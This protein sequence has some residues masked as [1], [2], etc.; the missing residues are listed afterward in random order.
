MNQT[1]VSLAIIKFKKFTCLYDDYLCWP[2]TPHILIDTTQLLCTIAENSWLIYG[3]T[4]QL[5]ASSQSS[6]G[7][8]AHNHPK[9]SNHV[10]NIS[11]MP[12]C[13]CFTCDVWMRIGD[14]GIYIMM[15]KRIELP[16]NKNK[17]HFH[18]KKIVQKHSLSSCLRRAQGLHHFK[19][20]TLILWRLWN[21]ELVAYNN[22]ESDYSH[23]QLGR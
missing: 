8:I 1:K 6:P 20:M 22:T 21:S 18:Q 19:I 13:L 7:S 2:T 9:I 10:M 4:F 15:I 12:P 17:L 3:G 23:R 11:H 14:S 16:T 5:H